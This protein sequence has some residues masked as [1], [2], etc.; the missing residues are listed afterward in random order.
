MKKVRMRTARTL[1]PWTRARRAARVRVAVPEPEEPIQEEVQEE[2]TAKDVQKKPTR[3]RAKQPSRSKRKTPWARTQ[4]VVTAVPAWTPE[5][6]PTWMQDEPAWMQEELAQT[7]V[8]G[9]GGP[10]QSYAPQEQES[11]QPDLP[12]VSEYVRIP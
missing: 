4:A 6:E 8:Q 3:A 9:Q 12:P 5:S 10:E 11:K 7:P 1:D 2:P